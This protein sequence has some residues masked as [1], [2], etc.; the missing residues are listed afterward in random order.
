MSQEKF[1]LDPPK[2]LEIRRYPDPILN[3]ACIEVKEFTQEIKTLVQNMFLTMYDENGIGLA[4]NQV[5]ETKSMF[6]MDTSNSGQKRRVFVNPEIKECR[7]EPERWKEGCL[8]F[9]D[10]FSFVPR[11]TDI[12]V[13]AQNENGEEFLL[14]L[15]GLDAICFQHEYDHLLGITFYDRLSPL[16]KKMIKKKILKLTK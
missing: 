6:I 4:A 11:H 15:Q 2:I 10:I 12:T 14:D 1:K 13:K 8:S 7:G 5:G 16:Q 9:P 3:Q